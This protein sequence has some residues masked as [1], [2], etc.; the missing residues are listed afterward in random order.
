LGKRIWNLEPTTGILRS[1]SGRI[2]G[3]WHNIG[4]SVSK[5]KKKCEGNMY[6]NKE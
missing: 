3:N 2:K 6:H 1:V 5:F 4:A